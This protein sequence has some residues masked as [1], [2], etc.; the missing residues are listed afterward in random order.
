MWVFMVSDRR[1]GTIAIDSYYT[2]ENYAI[3]ATGTWVPEVDVKKLLKEE[4]RICCAQGRRVKIKVF[5]R[6]N[7]TE[8]QMKLKPTHRPQRKIR[9][10]KQSKSKEV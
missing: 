2:L 6:G 1:A 9:R 3:S 10:R 5:A 4:R 7:P 8:A